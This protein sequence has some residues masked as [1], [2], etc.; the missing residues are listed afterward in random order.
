[1]LASITLVG[2]LVFTYETGYKRLFRAGKRRFFYVVWIVPV[3]L[4]VVG[5][6]GGLFYRDI[7]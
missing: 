1:M 6:V 4:S 5:V 7:F 2:H 3:L